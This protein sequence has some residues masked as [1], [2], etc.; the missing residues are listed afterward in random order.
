MIPTKRIG[1]RSRTNMVWNIKPFMDNSA[2]W[3]RSVRRI[4]MRTLERSLLSLWMSPWTLAKARSKKLVSSTKRTTKSKSQSTSN[5]S[6]SRISPTWQPIRTIKTQGFRSRIAEA[7]ILYSSKSSS[8]SS[9][10]EGALWQAQKVAIVVAPNSPLN[11][12]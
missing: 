10:V 5:A 4:Q 7:I 6:S 1:R 9:K 8:S 11:S 3:R 2:R 12:S